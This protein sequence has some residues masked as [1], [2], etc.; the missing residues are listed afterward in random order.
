MAAP[1]RAILSVIVPLAALWLIAI[2]QQGITLAHLAV[3]IL[4]AQL[5]AAF[6][7][8]TKVVYR[9]QETGVFEDFDFPLEGG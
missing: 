7:P 1:S 5:L 8:L 4:H 6:G 3:K 9:R 2:H